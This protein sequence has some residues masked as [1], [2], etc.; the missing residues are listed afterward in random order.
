M[1]AYAET[2]GLPALACG[3]GRERLLVE[4]GSRLRNE[5]PRN[6]LHHA[7][8]IPRRHSIRKASDQAIFATEAVV[9]VAPPA[10]RHGLD[11]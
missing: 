1:M 6:E 9:S 11:R 7:P 5:H 10:D 2:A 3:P 8:I 4:A